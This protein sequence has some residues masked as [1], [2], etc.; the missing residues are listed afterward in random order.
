MIQK[1]DVQTAVDTQMVNRWIETMADELKGQL[2]EMP[3]NQC[4][5]IGIQSGGVRIAQALR[6]LLDPSLPLGSLNI[7]FYRDD[8]SRIGL[9]PQVT[10]SEL[11][12][13]VDDRNIILVD[14]VLYSG[15]TIRAA[16]NEIFDYGRPAQ[17][18]LAVLVE[19]NGHELPIRA[20][21]KGHSLTLKPQQQI[22]LNGE[23]LALEIYQREPPGDEVQV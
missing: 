18:I 17:V 1:T 14:D 3:P 21:I 6:N 13:R 12:F 22:K 7:S 2:R 11:P 20:D 15:R 8:F 16:L 9:H 10:P 5:I 23:S 4:A 19:R